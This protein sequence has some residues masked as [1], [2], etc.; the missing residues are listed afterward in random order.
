MFVTNVC[1]KCFLIRYLSETN[2]IV[3]KKILATSCLAFTLILISFSTTKKPSSK[4]AMKV[5]DGFCNFVPSGNAVVGADSISV[6]SFY[7]S[8]TEITNVQ[9]QEF[10]N[11]LIKENDFEKLK[12]ARVDSLKWRELN[13]SFSGSKYG[14]YYHWHPAY[15][16]YPVVNVTKKGAELFCD[17]LN[18]KYDSLSDGELKLNFRIPTRAEWMRATRG[19][20]HQYT[21]S[22]AGPYLRNSKGIIVANF[23]RLGERNV[24]RNKETGKFEIVITPPIQSLTMSSPDVTAPAKS[25]WPNEY[26]FYNMNGNVSEMISDGDYAVGGDWRAPGYDIR[27]ESIKNF[28]DA[29]PTVGFRVVASFM[30][31]EK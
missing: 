16:N 29:H 25:Y 31:E 8:E 11:S 20:H 6:S 1:N 3:M 21:Y 9:Y 15:L 13:K 26:G 4:R 5:L 17:W 23:V 27:N 7:M 12:I 19:D 10:L 22:W 24:S 14:D 2:L 18:A 30:K 28:N